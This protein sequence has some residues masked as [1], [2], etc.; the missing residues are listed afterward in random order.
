MKVNGFARITNE[1]KWL[2][3]IKMKANGFARIENESK[4]YLK[5]I[6]NESK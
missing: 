6:E 1:S 4:W 3:R 5:K 2:S